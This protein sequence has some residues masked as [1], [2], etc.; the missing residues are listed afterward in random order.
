MFLAIDESESLSKKVI[1][2]IL[3]PLANLPDFEKK[4]VECR[5]KHKLFGEIK[6]DSVD[7]AYIDGYLDVI[8]CFLTDSKVTYHSM[9]YRD[10]SLKYKAA[11][12]LIRTIC[13]KLWNAGIRES[14]YILFDN[15]TNVGATETQIVRRF[16]N[17]D[18]KIKQKIEFCNQGVSHVL[19]ALQVADIITGSV[20]FTV[21]KKSCQQK[22]KRC[23]LLHIRWQQKNSFRFLSSLFT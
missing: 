22:Q 13:W 1:G 2:G 16:L 7:K 8:N 11:Y 23:Y 6:W 5:I 14:L 12:V 15:D 3:L 10:R 9:C 17:N 18:S 4:I 20:C 21:N 19:G